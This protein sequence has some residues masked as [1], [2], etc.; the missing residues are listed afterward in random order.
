MTV[1]EPDRDRSLGFEFWQSLT[2]PDVCGRAA[3][4]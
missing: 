4:P 1:Q 2:F 3:D